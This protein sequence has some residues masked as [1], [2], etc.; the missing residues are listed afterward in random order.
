MS[1]ALSQVPNPRSRNKRT[2]L[3]PFH[4]ANTRFF[5]QFLFWNFCNF[6]EEG[7]DSFSWILKRKNFRNSF[8]EKLRRK[9]LLC[10]HYRLSC[11]RLVGRWNDSSFRGGE[12]KD[13]K[14]CSRS[15]L[16]DLFRHTWQSFLTNNQ[17]LR[18][19]QNSRECSIR[20]RHWRMYL[21]WRQFLSS[22]KASSLE[23]LL[24]FSQIWRMYI[25]KH[26]S[27]IFDIIS[28]IAS[29]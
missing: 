4:F 19:M 25:R 18:S 16:D 3:V 7:E 1:S 29:H 11:T 24:D 17:R 9:D 2:F 23:I 5:Y 10:L 20:Y 27:P 12:E 14:K 21:S 15:N 8:F 28:Q 6:K 22:A 26:G 13:T